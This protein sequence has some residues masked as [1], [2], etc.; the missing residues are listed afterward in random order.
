MADV[1]K[2]QVVDYLSKH[3]RDRPRRR[4]TK[5]LEDKW[6]VKAAPVAVAAA[7]AARRR[8]R[9]GCAAA[10]KTEFTVVLKDAG[11]NKI[12]VIKVVREVTGL[13]LKEAKDL[14]DG[15]PK[16]VKEGVAKADAESI[17]EEARRGRREGRG[18]VRPCDGRTHSSTVR[19][20]RSPRRG[21]DG[22]RPR[23]AV[24]RAVVSVLRQEEPNGVADSEQFP[25]CGR[26][27][28][29]SGRS[30]TS[31]T[32]S[33]SRSRVYEKFL[34]TDVPAGQARGRR[35]CRASSR[36][37]S[38]SRTS[39]R[40]PRSSSS[41][42]R[43]SKPKYDVDECRQRGMTFAAPIKVTVRLVV[44]DT[45]EETGAQ[46]IRDV[47]EQEVYFGEIPLMTDNGTFIINGTERVV[48]SQLH[49]CPGVF[50]DH[51]KG[52]THSSRASCSTARASSRT[53]AR[54]STSS[55]TPRTSST[56]ASTA[57]ASCT[58]RCCCARSA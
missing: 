6:G 53:A 38:R 32:S 31:R 33:T 27:S 39:P 42:T 41:A 23:T 3:V 30:S 1:T 28:R 11:G 10:E 22:S 16:T 47:K 9:R 43:S 57:A 7:G 55:S 21:R 50:F 20:T 2:E 37:S 13:G 35:A 34:Q 44:W 17:E 12:D 24:C 19:S 56:S 14:V 8:R 15:A 29:R 40:R 18:Q 52:K 5:E 25:G 58:R 51:D 4:S 36:A 54:G 46:S 49:R 45:D 26:A 48:V